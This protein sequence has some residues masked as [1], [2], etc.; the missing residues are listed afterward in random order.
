MKRL[1]IITTSLVF[2]LC[3]GARIWAQSDYTSKLIGELKDKNAYVQIRAARELG[4]ARDPLSIEFLIDAL[5][6][7][8]PR[9][10]IFAART[11]GKIGDSMAVK[12]LILKNG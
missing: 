4:R 1:I 8:H 11:L 12:P 5:K 2:V 9:V 6:D 3:A 10:R 7:E